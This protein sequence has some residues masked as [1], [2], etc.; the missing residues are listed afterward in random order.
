MPRNRVTDEITHNLG[1]VHQNPDTARKAAFK[2]KL[3][4][5]AGHLKPIDDWWE[6]SLLDGYLSMLGLSHI[7]LDDCPDASSVSSS[8]AM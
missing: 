6:G 1:P 8:Q 7:P 5:D 4:A 2:I 3:M